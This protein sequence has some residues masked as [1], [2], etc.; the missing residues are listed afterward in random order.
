MNAAPPKHHLA[1]AKHWATGISRRKR[2]IP[3]ITTM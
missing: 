2:T 3:D 1:A